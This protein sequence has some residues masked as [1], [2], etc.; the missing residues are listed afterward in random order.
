[1]ADI[2]IP[3]LTQ[4]TSL[5]A[6]QWIH[7]AS[8]GSDYRISPANF[9]QSIFGGSVIGGTSSI[10]IMTIGGTQSATNKRF[11]NVKINSTASVTA[12]SEQLNKMDGCTS[13]TAELNKLTGVTTTPT[14]FN[15][16]N[17]LTGN[18][19]TALDAKL[20]DVS[21][22]TRYIMQADILFSAAT[23]ST[24]HVLSYSDIM[25]AMG[26]SSLINTWAIDANSVTIQTS[27]IGTSPYTRTSGT[28]G[29][30]FTVSPNP[31]ST[32]RLDNL[33]LTGLTAQKT[34]Q[35]SIGMKFVTYANP[36]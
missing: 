18:V 21:K 6:G 30:S 34:Y 3:N 15:Y 24:T 9:S 19:Q 11:D 5:A 23:G 8:S 4:T 29:Y 1:M 16:C 28:Y 35:V 26:L 27:L 14:Q 7:I 22:S 12:T 31:T 25:T 10:D 36:A 33:T 13:T 17:T 32:Y 2:R 20:V